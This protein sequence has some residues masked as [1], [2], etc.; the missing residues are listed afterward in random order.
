MKNHI[1]SGFKMS[2]KKTQTIIYFDF[3]Y[4]SLLKNSQFYI[5]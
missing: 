2:I 5:R 3:T 4:K 1:A